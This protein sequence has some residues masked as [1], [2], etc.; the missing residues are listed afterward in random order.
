MPGCAFQSAVLPLSLP[1]G[2][3][4]VYAMC[5]TV[6]S[7]SAF[8]A[9]VYSSSSSYQSKT[10]PGGASASG[11][12][13]LDTG[14]P[15]TGVQVSRTTYN[16]PVIFNDS[17]YEPLAKDYWAYSSTMTRSDNFKTTLMF[18]PSGGIWI[19]VTQGTWNWGGSA[20]YAYPGPWTGPTGATTTPPSMSPATG[21]GN[22]PTWTHNVTEL[23]WTK[24][25][26]RPR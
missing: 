1:S 20:S 5:Q 13:F 21:N 4:G 10:L 23:V 24:I 15:V 26:P 6:T 9:D 2:V 3:T 22:F 25:V 14:F 7:T 17:P 19:P 18:Q 8:R 11:I 12:Q 16:G